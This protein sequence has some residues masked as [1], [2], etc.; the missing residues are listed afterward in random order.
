MRKHLDE[1]DLLMRKASGITIATRPDLAA[2][3][4]DIAAAERAPNLAL[5]ME[6][7]AEREAQQHQ[8]RASEVQNMTQLPHVAAPFRWPLIAMLGR[9][10]AGSFDALTAHAPQLRD[11]RLRV[12]SAWS[13]GSQEVRFVLCDRL[14]N[15]GIYLLL[16]LCEADS[17]LRLWPWRDAPLCLLDLEFLHTQ[18]DQECARCIA[19][20]AWVP[21]PHTT[22]ATFK[23]L[24]GKLTRYPAA[25]V[26][27]VRELLG[28]TSLDLVRARREHLGLPSS[29]S[30]LAQL[31]ALMTL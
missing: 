31:R 4:Y 6:N 13:T 22:L 10:Q 1:L 16:A 9:P 30:A 2:F 27:A 17:V 12:T 11:D 3:G 5:H 23:L 7:E 25:Q 21:V 14:P 26:R 29:A 24:A 18:G 15:R 8:E 28:A 20:G 19:T